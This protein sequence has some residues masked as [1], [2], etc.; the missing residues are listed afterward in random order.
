MTFENR[1]AVRGL[2]WLSA[3]VPFELAEKV[4]T[5]GY[6]RPTHGPLVVA[7]RAASATAELVAEFAKPRGATWVFSGWLRRPEW[8]LQLAVT[9][10]RVDGEVA[11]RIGTVVARDD[12]KFV[13]RMIGDAI[14]ELCAR[15]KL[16]LSAAAIARTQRVLSKDY[17][18]F[19]LFGRGAAALAGIAEVQEKVWAE[20]YANLSAI[21]CEVLGAKPRIA[22]TGE[23]PMLG[24]VNTI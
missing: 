23:Y 11:T 22:S 18:A 2:D 8:E 13:H 5:I 3:A 1:S 15:A 16:P 14:V 9:L 17:Y 21:G 20:T 19:T 6:F 4:A 12:F 10:W 7:G 24:D